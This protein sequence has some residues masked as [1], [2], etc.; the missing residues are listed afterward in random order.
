MPG[1]QCRR[2]RTCIALKVLHIGGIAGVLQRIEIDDVVPA[3]DHQTPDE[4]GSNETGSA[5]YE[6]SH[7]E[8]SGVTGYGGS[9]ITEAL[10]MFALTFSELKN[11]FGILLILS[12]FASNR[13]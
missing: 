8:F 12:V 5:G 7:R 10:R 4:M 9:G 2:A 3:L 11:A 6:D 13:S 1:R